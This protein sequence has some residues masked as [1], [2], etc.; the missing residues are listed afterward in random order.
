ADR[1]G[2]RHLQRRLDRY[3]QLPRP[4]ALK[5]P[6]S[7]VRAPGWS[8]GAF[9]LLAASPVLTGRAPGGTICPR[10]AHPSSLVD[11]GRDRMSSLS[12][13]EASLIAYLDARHDEMIEYTAELVATPS[14]NPPGDER[15][16]VS[17]LAARLANL[18]GLGSEILAERP[19]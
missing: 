14:M 4:N 16:V 12:A 2:R 10:G 6:L 15:A 13:A 1:R 9:S 11:E 7:F 8:P 17:S 5:R 19:E 18:T 3:P